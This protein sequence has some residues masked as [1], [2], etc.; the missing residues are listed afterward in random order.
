MRELIVDW[1]AVER[2]GESWL[3]SRYPEFVLLE[4]NYAVRSGE[5]DLV[6]E[7]RPRDMAQDAEL[8]FVEIRARGPGSWTNALESVDHGK[9][10]RLKR[11]IACYLMK[12]RGSAR[13][14]RVDVLG[15]DGRCFE[16][17]QDVWLY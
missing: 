5:I 16:H 3:L 10:R 2:A 11:A 14:A 9:R 13:S 17:A 12:Y 1:R 7:H 6:F 15:W 8:I 4:R